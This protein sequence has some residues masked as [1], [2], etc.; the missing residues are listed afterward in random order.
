MCVTAG[1]GK[2]K[3]RGKFSSLLRIRELVPRSCVLLLADGGGGGGS[4][5]RSFGYF[6]GSGVRTD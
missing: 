3:T 6:Q 2:K 4:F 5:A 1:K